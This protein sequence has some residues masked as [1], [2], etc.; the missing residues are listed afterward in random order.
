[1]TPNDII[2]ILTVIAAADRRTIGENDVILWH[3]IIGDLPKDDAMQAVLDHVREQPG[4]WLE[5]G[6]IVAG[7]RAIRRDRAMRQPLE[8]IEAHND[9]LTPRITELAEAKSIDTALKYTRRGVTSLRSVPCPHCNVGVGQ[10][11]YNS[12][13]RRAFLGHHDARMKAAAGINTP[14]PP[15]PPP[16]SPDVIV[17]D[18][19]CDTCG[20]HELITEQE[21]D[22]GTC[23]RCWPNVNG[24]NTN[25][26]QQSDTA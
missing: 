26:Q 12:A 15:A 13:T 24:H 16:G 4:V 7:V 18:T 5:P 17:A 20:E 19:V 25:H 1:M 21:T 22:R 2:D 8:Q 6:H 11:C 3:K 10:P 14:P 9:R 23:D